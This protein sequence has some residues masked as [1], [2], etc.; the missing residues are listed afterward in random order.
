MLAVLPLGKVCLYLRPTP[1]SF[2]LDVFQEGCPRIHNRFE[3][4]FAAWSHTFVRVKQH[5]EFSIR[6]V[7]FIPMKK[8]EL[9][10]SSRASPTH[11]I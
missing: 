9:Y 8:A 3:G 6:F 7:D 2:L 10:V 5:R 1:V 11:C 4:I